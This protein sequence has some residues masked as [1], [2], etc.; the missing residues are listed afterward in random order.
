M[1]ARLVRSAAS[2]WLVLLAIMFSNGIVRV[3]VLQPRLGEDAARR[4]ATLVGVALVVAFSWAYVR[5]AG[6]LAARELLLVG[7]VWLVLTLSFEFGFG[8]ASGRSWRELLAD[9]DLAHGRLW[10]LVLAATLLA[11]WVW[12]L[13]LRPRSR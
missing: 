2:A 6:P 3:L 10:P 13:V 12:G 8:R 1:S 11:P 7:V 5:H 9:Y 4:L